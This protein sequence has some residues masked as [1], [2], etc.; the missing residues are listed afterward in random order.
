MPDDDLDQRLPTMLSRRA[1]QVES[2]LSGPDLRARAALDGGQGGHRVARIAGPILVAAAVLVIAIAPQVLN[3][4][5]GHQ[6]SPQQPGTSQTTEPVRPTPT[7]TPTTSTPVPS[8]PGTR[9][10]PIP[11]S[12]PTAPTLST[13]TVSAPTI[14]QPGA[15]E[16]PS[17]A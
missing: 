14:S 8:T 3:Q 16:R 1:G 2:S 7:P 10:A 9:E 17:G 5:G 4:H 15:T 6:V 13:P 11:T 12:P